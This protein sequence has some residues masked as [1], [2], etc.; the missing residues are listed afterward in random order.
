MYDNTINY[1]QSIP[2]T[3]EVAAT[4]L[5]RLAAAWAAAAL[6]SRT[7]YVQRSKSIKVYKKKSRCAHCIGTHK[8]SHH[9]RV[10]A[11]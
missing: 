7:C 1:Q 2:F 3:C 4:L 8:V 5:P 10:N 6:G 11:D 9:R